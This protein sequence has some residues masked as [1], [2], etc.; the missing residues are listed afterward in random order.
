[1]GKDRKTDRPIF[2]GEP[3]FDIESYLVPHFVWPFGPETSGS[4]E[5][6]SV[7]GRAECR[8][9]VGINRINLEE[10]HPVKTIFLQP[11]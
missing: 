8:P 9:S 4:R 3:S 10:Q 5:A 1:V 7:R 11:S 2:D 6:H